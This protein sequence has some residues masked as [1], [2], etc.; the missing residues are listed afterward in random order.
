[1]RRPLVFL[2]TAA[3][4]SC[5]PRGEFLAVSDIPPEKA[6]I[7]PES[8][9]R[10]AVFVAT[11][12]KEEEGAYGFGRADEASFL[13]YDILVPFNRKPGEVN[14]PRSAKSAD[15]AKDFLTLDAPSP[16]GAFAYNTILVNLK[17]T[18]LHHR[19]GWDQ[20]ATAR[21]HVFRRDN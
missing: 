13:R 9:V 2:L 8:G 11:T 5:S 15:P 16:A 19:P 12:R 6:A 21:S 7:A 18:D 1:M 3:L 17:K 20:L 10:E 4:L 14:W